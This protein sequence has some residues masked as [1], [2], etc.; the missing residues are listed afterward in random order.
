MGSDEDS[1]PDFALN[2]YRPLPSCL[3]HWFEFTHFNVYA[4]LFD[5]GILFVCSSHLYSNFSF[6]GI[7]CVLEIFIKADKF[8]HN[9]EEM[10]LME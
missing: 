8:S 10:K 7:N 1:A 2:S 3:V 4:N 5:N 6:G 9:K